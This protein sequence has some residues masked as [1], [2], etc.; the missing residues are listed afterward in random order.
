MIGT[1][2]RRRER[3]AENSG[4]TSK[5]GMVPNS[6]QNST[7]R[8]CSFPPFS[9]ATANSSRLKFWIIK[10]AMKFLVVSSSGRMRKMADFSEPNFSALMALSKQ[11][12]CSNSESRNALRRESTVDM[13]EAM[14]CSA[15]LSAAPANHLALWSGGSLPTQMLSR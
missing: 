7:T 12:T 8:F 2:V 3:P 4:R 10:P 15:L 14:A 11:S 5:G 1:S 13:T 6:S 9:S